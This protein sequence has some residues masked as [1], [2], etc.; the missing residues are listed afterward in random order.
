MRK[1]PIGDSQAESS[2]DL[3]AKVQKNQSQSPEAEL[4]C[5]G[6][7]KPSSLLQANILV[8]VGTNPNLHFAKRKRQEKENRGKG[9]SNSSREL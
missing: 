6:S 4:P 3:P 9:R 2:L 8:L 5:Q 7:F 1:V